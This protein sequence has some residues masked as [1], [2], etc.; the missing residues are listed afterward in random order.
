MS[1]ERKALYFD[2][3]R[4]ERVERLVKLVGELLDASK[5]LDDAPAVDVMLA[6]VVRSV[7]ISKQVE[8]DENEFFD[9][10]V[11]MYEWTHVERTETH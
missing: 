7:V 1:D 8:I 2:Q 10:V 3:E 11:K 9:V 5:E 6:C 4:K